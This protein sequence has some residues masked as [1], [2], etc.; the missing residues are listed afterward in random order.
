[1]KSANGISEIFGSIEPYL[2][3][4]LIVVTIIGLDFTCCQQNFVFTTP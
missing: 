3:K 1:M 4:H 2:R